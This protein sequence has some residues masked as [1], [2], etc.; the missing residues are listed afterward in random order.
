M[1]QLARFP[2]RTSVVRWSAKGRMYGWRSSSN[3]LSHSHDA[4]IVAV[5]EMIV[6]HSAYVISMGHLCRSSYV[7]RAPA[8]N[9]S[10]LDA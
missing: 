3:R 1:V 9:A 2:A 5:V 7:Y 6:W 8:V 10:H 4:K